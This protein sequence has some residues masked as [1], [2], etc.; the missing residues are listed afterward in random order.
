[1]VHNLEFSGGRTP[2]HLLS[3]K[4]RHYPATSNKSRKLQCNHLD[5][6]VSL[7]VLPENYPYSVGHE[8]GRMTKT[9]RFAKMHHSRPEILGFKLCFDHS[10]K[11]STCCDASLMI[12]ALP[13][14]IVLV[15]I[16][17]NQSSSQLKVCHINRY[18]NRPFPNYL[19]PLFQSE[20]WCLSF[21]MKISFHLHVN[22]S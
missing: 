10:G 18:S 22:E 1:M 9:A 11:L 6:L 5:A 2:P 17:C 21:H 16:C 19:W 4:D 8:S 15:L 20:S 12:V 7:K 3:G 14:W 13:V